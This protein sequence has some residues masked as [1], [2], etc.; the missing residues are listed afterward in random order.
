M[1]CC[2]DLVRTNITTQLP[3]SLQVEL[4]SLFTTCNPNFINSHLRFL[5]TAI[6]HPQL[7]YPTLSLFIRPFFLHSNFLRNLTSKISLHF[8]KLAPL[9]HFY[10]SSIFQLKSHTVFNFSFGISRL[11]LSNTGLDLAYL[12]ARSRSIFLHI[13]LHPR[14][15]VTSLST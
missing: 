1:F 13:P 6:I 10:Y 14:A 9:S 2:I 4:D 15:F 3:S 5:P 7:Q 8:S 12:Q 11:L